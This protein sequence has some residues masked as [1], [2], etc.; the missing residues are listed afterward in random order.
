MDSSP[1]DPDSSHARIDDFLDLRDQSP[2]PDESKRIDL[3]IGKRVLDVGGSGKKGGP[4]GHE[5]VDQSD[6]LG[7]HHGGEEGH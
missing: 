3:G 6:L 5:I 2:R 7:D 1:L 4:P